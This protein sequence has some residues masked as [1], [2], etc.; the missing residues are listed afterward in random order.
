MAVTGLAAVLKALKREEN[1]TRKAVAGAIY[2]EGQAILSESKKQVPV[3]TGRLRQSANVSRPKPTGDPVA[4]LSYGTDYALAVHERLEVN[5][6]TGKAKFLEDPVNAAKL[7]YARRIADRARRLRL[8]G[9]G[10]ADLPGEG[11]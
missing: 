2:Q 8:A 11:D 1:A 5:H 6:P 4:I 9:G 3:D 10:L 7:G